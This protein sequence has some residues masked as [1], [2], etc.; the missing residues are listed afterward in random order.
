MEGRKLLLVAVVAARGGDDGGGLAVPTGEVVVAIDT[1]DA[2]PG[3]EV[4]IS[5]GSGARQAVSSRH[6]GSILADAAVSVV[7]AET[8]ERKQ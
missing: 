2:G 7:L 5:W 8:F 4:L 3:Q 1:L 6:A